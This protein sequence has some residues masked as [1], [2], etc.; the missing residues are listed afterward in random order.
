MKQREDSVVELINRA[1]AGNL[2]LSYLR[3]T[4]T[5]T[6]TNGQ[7]PALFV[8][9]G[10]DKVVEQSRR[11]WDGYPCKRRLEVTFEIWAND[12]ETQIRELFAALRS[13][14]F[15]APLSTGAAMAEDR[16]VGP[17]NPGIPGIVCMQ[18]VVAITHMDTGTN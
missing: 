7:Y 14:I 12:K 4:P 17:F 13:S 5:D 9:E 16:S 18:L 11:S 8:L 2:G 10:M 3:R 6:P 1:K 15:S